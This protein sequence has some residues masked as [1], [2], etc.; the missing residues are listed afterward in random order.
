MIFLFEIDRSSVMNLKIVYNERI[1]RQIY[2]A[3]VSYPEI[4]NDNKIVY[5]K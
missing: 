5:N 3:L 2:K 4:S 1:I